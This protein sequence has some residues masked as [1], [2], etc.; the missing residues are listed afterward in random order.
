MTTSDAPTDI[1]KD[2]EMTKIERE[3]NKIVGQK[4]IAQASC[5]KYKKAYSLDL[6]NDKTMAPI[7]RLTI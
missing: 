1:E 5:L 3:M 2:D 7:L 4:S 6:K